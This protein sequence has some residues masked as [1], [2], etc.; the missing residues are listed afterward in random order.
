M[1]MI[2]EAPRLG[3][4]GDRQFRR[5][6]LECVFVAECDHDARHY[7]NTFGHFSVLSGW[8]PACDMGSAQAAT[9]RCE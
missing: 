3:P 7:F 2:G 9:W 4:C 5:I 6:C 8:F 1:E